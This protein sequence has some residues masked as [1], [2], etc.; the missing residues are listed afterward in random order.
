MGH[1]EDDALGE[2]E[3]VYAAATLREAR[4]IEEALTGHGIDYAVE[5]EELGRTP[6]FGS[7][8][9]G[10]VFYVRPSQAD[11]CRTLLAAIGKGVI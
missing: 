1:I 9:H 11:Y 8:R 6:I 2:G 5:V 3:R 7:V 4:R 10:A